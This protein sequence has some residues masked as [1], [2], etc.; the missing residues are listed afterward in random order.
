MKV[1]KTLKKTIYKM[2]PNVWGKH[3]WTSI[4]FIALAYPHYPTELEQSNYNSFFNNLSYVFLRNPKLH[5]TVS[6]EEEED[7]PRVGGQW[8]IATLSRRGKRSP[9]AGTMY[10]C[11]PAK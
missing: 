2:D 9:A 4:H 10:L 7:D 5:R 11:A 8:R 6:I 1:A 3:M